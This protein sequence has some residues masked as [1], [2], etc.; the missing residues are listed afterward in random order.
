[1]FFVFFCPKHV[2]NVPVSILIGPQRLLEA[3]MT[4]HGRRGDMLRSSSGVRD[5]RRRSLGGIL[6]LCAT[7]EWIRK[8]SHTDKAAKGEMSIWG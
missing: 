8:C 5:Y 3:W 7:S 2:V 1:M 6:S 4:A